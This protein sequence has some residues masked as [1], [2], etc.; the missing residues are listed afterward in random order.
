MCTPPSPRCHRSTCSPHS[1]PRAQG[2]PAAAASAALLVISILIVFH[3][4]PPRSR[5]KSAPPPRATVIHSAC[6]RRRPALSEHPHP[7]P[8]HFCLVT[9][10][11]PPYS[12]GGDAVFVQ[13]LARELCARGHRVD[14]VHS[15]DAFH[16]L[17]GNLTA[18]PPAPEPGL[19]LHSLTSGFDLLGPLAV[20]QT[21]SPAFLSG[22]LRQLLNQ[23][24]DV[25]H[26]HNV[27]LIGGP[28]ILTYGNAVKLYTPHEYWL[29]CPTHVLF[30]NRREP[31]TQ[32]T[33]LSCV[34]HHRR[35]PQLW[36]HTGKLA[37]AARHIDAFLALSQ[38]SID[39]HRRMGFDGPFHLL[40]P[41]IPEAPPAE[42]AP[43]ASHPPYFLYVGRLEY[44]KGV[45][46]LFPHFHDRLDAELWIAGAGSQEAELRRAAAGNPR[47]R[48]L[49]FVSEPRLSSL[50]RHARAVIM[51]SLCFEVF[52]LV[53]LEA[54]RQRVPVIVRRLGGLAE[55]AAG[56]AAA[57]TYDDAPQLDTAL[58]RILDDPPLRDQ[59]GAR[60]YAAFLQ[61]WTPQVHLNRYLALIETIRATKSSKAPN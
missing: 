59:L 17:G 11:Y 13:R 25:I 50:Y 42:P 32:P 30:R 1:S 53:L 60:G 39:T 21:G 22:R 48:F 24:F 52:P 35:P 47:I 16:S 9:T 20:Q 8:L 44:L 49:G 57:L 41:F 10:F 58:R 34:L 18:P 37:A 45:H 26:F 51:P 14:V 27:S 33:C 4:P 15:V 19:R 2:K 40:P 23:P 55:V 29:V 36:R 3:C 7:R 38:F 56:S 54:F 46:T 6:L 5:T 28:D 43:A 61:S 12:F 31:C